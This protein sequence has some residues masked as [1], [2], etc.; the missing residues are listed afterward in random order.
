MMIIPEYVVLFNRHRYRP[1]EASLYHHI[2]CDDDD[3]YCSTKPAD[4]KYN[5][6]I[7]EEASFV[8]PPRDYS[9]ALPKIILKI[10]QVAEAIRLGTLEV[11]NAK[12]KIQEFPGR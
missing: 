2:C 5:K 10:P 1:F 6:T 3:C 8:V 9:K 11:A 7:R 12:Q 4:I